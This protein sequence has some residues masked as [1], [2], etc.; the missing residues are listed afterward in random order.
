MRNTFQFIAIFTALALIAGC[1]DGSIATINVTGT[2]TVDGE[3]LAGANVSF[4]P[5]SDGQGN[6]GFA[7]TDADG[8]FRLQTLL[9]AVDAGTTPGEYYVTITKTE[10][11]ETTS[12]SDDVEA[13]SSQSLTPPPRSLIPVRYGQRGA[14]P[15]LS[16]TVSAERGA[17][18]VFN[19]DLKS[20]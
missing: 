8:R 2:V 11:V 1:G 19:F 15:E 5:K 9:G 20:Q 14:V 16:A 12:S 7:V 3:P 6:P 10:S 13:S 4:S 18:N 17:S